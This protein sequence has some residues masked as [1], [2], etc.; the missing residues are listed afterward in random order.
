MDR[1][2]TGK[3]VLLTGHTGFKGTWMTQVL[4]KLGA[5]VCGYSLPNDNPY[6]SSE[7]YR[8][9]SPKVVKSV[10]SNIENYEIL[11][12]TV[13]EF[14]P[15]I[16]FHLAS[17]SSLYR[18]ME[19][20]HHILET[21]MMG[22]LNILESCNKSSSV[23]S[24]VIITSDKAYKNENKEIKYSEEDLLDGED[25][26]STSKVCQELLSKCYQKTFFDEKNIGVATAR[27]SN[28]I[29]PGDYNKSRLIPYLLDQFQNNSIPVIRNPQAIRPWQYILDVVYGYLLL[30][31]KLYLE[32]NRYSGAYN[33]GPEEDGFK[34]VGKLVE[35][36]SRQFDNKEYVITGSTSITKEE[37][38]IL[39]LNN[40][41]AKELLNWIPKISFDE[42]IKLIVEFAKKEANGEK[43]SKL[44]NEYINRYK[45]F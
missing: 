28:I 25:P 10:A 29:G 16:V 3:K 22:V 41:K 5:D 14:M 6:V 42:S 7:F 30:G 13:E 8:R 34:E 39:M 37:K 26:Y 36:M 2:W 27:A 15:E 1:F 4:L 9:V 32:G 40:S 35:E 44:V 33:F 23:K 17:H 38:K 11:N 21:N 18:S 24:I 43:T 20:P 31:Q 19:I 45:E 12:R